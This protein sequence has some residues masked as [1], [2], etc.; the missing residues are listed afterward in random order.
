MRDSP[1]V[2]IENTGRG[3]K[4]GQKERNRTQN[5]SMMMMMCWYC[6][7]YNNDYANIL[8]TS[9]YSIIILGTVE[10]LLL[11]LL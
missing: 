7:I 5:D 10:V 9:I 4:K 2:I 11:T 1:F 3:L 8:Y 6:E